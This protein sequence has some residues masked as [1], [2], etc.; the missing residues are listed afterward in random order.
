M[1]FKLL[2]KHAFLLSAAASEARQK[3]LASKYHATPE[4]VKQLADIDPTNNGTYTEFLVREFTKGRLGLN[5]MALE[6]AHESLVK[7]NRLKNSQKFKAMPDTHTDILAYDWYTFTAQMA[8]MD[9]GQ[10]SKKEQKREV[11]RRRQEYLNNG[12]E[13]LT[14]QRGY[15]FFKVTTPE[16]AMLMGE[17]SHW[18]TK[19]ENY[20]RT[21][22]ARGPLYVIVQAEVGGTYG[23]D[24]YA[25]FSIP[26]SADDIE[27]FECQDVDGNDFG[28]KEAEGHLYYF[29][30]GNYWW[31]V[32]VLVNYDKTLAH[33]VNEGFVFNDWDDAHPYDQC[34]YCEKYIDEDSPDAYYTDD[35]PFCSRSC[36]VSNYSD[37]IGQEVERLYHPDMSQNEKIDAELEFYINSPESPERDYFQLIEK[38]R[39]IKQPETADEK[40]TFDTQLNNA[41]GGARATQADIDRI[42]PGLKKED[43]ER[44]Y[45]YLNALMGQRKDLD[46]LRADAVDHVERML[47]PDNM[48]VEKI[49][50]EGG[51]L[52][53]QPKA[54][55]LLK[56]RARMKFLAKPTEEPELSTISSNY[57]IP[58]EIRTAAMALKL[59]FENIKRGQKWPSE[60]GL[61]DSFLK[62]SEV[63]KKLSNDLNSQNRRLV[64]QELSRE[65]IQRGHANVRHN[66]QM[67]D[68]DSR[69]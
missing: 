12:C 22:L 44:V 17:G 26:T 2:F 55:S 61:V 67:G 3:A 63:W 13:L 35:G 66:S 16:A 28:K 46:A 38:A 37:I 27:H 9:R 69:R 19:N 68:G 36:F 4:A 14:E 51:Y 34:A 33:W 15:A 21:Y 60:N 24:R 30:D 18:C 52:D 50:R 29:N 54:S 42:I 32:E 8:E 48:D 59:E 39:K 40:W 49:L 31:L 23:S 65:D 41:R 11:E 62:G 25:Q 20:A 7:F 53:S 58:P 5:Q 64:L 45:A 56:K 10:L 6:E 47:N 57:P 1:P 43:A